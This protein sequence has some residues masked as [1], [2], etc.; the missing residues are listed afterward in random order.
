MTEQEKKQ[1]EYVIGIDL[2]HGETS[3]ALCSLQWD[4]AISALDPA[5]DLEMG[6]IRR[7]FH[8]LL[9]FWKMVMRILVMLHLI[10]MC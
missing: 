6:G 10:P 8:L 4:T 5:K 7:S 9:L 2:G 3:A 1:Y